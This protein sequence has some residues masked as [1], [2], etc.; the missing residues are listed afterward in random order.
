LLN[1]QED[2]RKIYIARFINT[3]HNTIVTGGVMTDT[4]T[5]SKFRIWLNPSTETLYNKF[6]YLK[7]QLERFRTRK[8]MSD[9]QKTILGH[10]DDYIEKVDN[11]HLQKLTAGY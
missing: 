2:R 3:C 4:T 11:C 8:D 6:Y 5:Q 9:E 1:L 7:K 10:C